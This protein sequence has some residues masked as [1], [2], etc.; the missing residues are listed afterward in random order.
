MTYTLSSDKGKKNKEKDNKNH[1][2]ENKTKMNKAKNKHNVDNT[3]Y[4]GKSK[5]RLI[6][7]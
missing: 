7:V 4:T 3:E 6:Y 2:K 5:V 1:K